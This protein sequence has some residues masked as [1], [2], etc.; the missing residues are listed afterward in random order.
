MYRYIHQYLCKPSGVTDRLYRIP[1]PQ[2]IDLSLGPP[3]PGKTESRVVGIVLRI[4]RNEALFIPFR[5]H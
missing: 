2:R 1:L 5:R 4:V 3:S